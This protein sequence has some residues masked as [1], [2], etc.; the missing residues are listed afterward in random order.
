MYMNNSERVVS[1][2][3][4]NELKTLVMALAAYNKLDK[5]DSRTDLME[6]LINGFLMANDLEAEVI[7][8]RP[9]PNAPMGS[10]A[11]KMYEAMYESDVRAHS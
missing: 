9:N 11:Y 3:S 2:F 10:A 6:K 4:R 7:D 1:A 8:V 5:R